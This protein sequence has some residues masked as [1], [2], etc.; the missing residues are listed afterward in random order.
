MV[1]FKQV[2]SIMNGL[3]LESISGEIDAAS[4]QIVERNGAGN[5]FVGWLDYASRLPESELDDIIA[6]AK[7]IRENY[8][9]LVCIGIGGSYLGGRCV[10]EAI[11]GL[12]PQDDFKVVYMGDTLSASYTTQILN[13]LKGRNYAVNVISKSGTTTEPAVAFRLIK[14]QM[15]ERWGHEQLKDRVIA[16]TDRAKGALKT[17]ANAEGYKCFVIP[18]DIGGRFSVITPVGL[19]P[20]ACANVDIKAF[21][22]GVADGEKDYGDADWHKNIAYQYG[23]TRYL[24]ETKYHFASEMF[25]TYEPQDMMIGEWLKQ[26][27]GE[28]LGKDG[29][30]LLPTSGVFTTDLHSMGQFIQ[31]GTNCL[32]ET[33]IKE[34][35]TPEDHDVVVKEDAENLDNLNYLAGK[36]L[37][38]INGKAYEAVLKAHT[39]GQIDAN[40]IELPKMDAYN[41]GNLFYF[42]FRATA[43]SGYLLHINPFDQPGVELYKHNMFVLL[44]KPGVK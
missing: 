44:G 38:Y 42:F 39:E 21:I 26:L 16:T 5:D 33:V 12:F 31:Q 11:N 43:I 14:E 37:S 9:T 32:F 7:R 24:M 3:D 18:D 23:A 1:T 35:E 13:Y 27:F 25:V 28:S 19:F 20:M 10:I 40:V 29:K 4:K 15:V 36:K 30:G 34:V 6:T 8:D 22:K 41:L 17:E 2:G